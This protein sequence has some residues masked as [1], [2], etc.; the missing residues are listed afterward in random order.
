MTTRGGIRSITV[1]RYED[2]ADQMLQRT[3]AE[4]GDRLMLK[5]G[6]AD[7]IDIDGMDDLSGRAKSY[8]LRAHLDFLMVD[9]ATGLGRFAVELDG[10]Q[11]W[12]DHRTRE[13]DRLKNDLC[14]RAG[15]P[16]LRIT[17]NF[18]RKIGCWPVLTYLT[19]A[20]YLSE[21]FH[22]TQERG[23]IP[24]DESFD[25]QNFFE[26]DASGR[27]TFRATDLRVRQALREH[28]YAGRLPAPCPDLFCTKLVDEGAVQAHAWMSVAPD[29]YLIS[30]V[31]VRDFQFPGIAPFELLEQ[32]AMG[33][34]GEL[35]DQWFRGEGVAQNGRDLGKAVGE[36][37]EAI[38]AVGRTERIVYGP[39]LKA[40]DTS[41]VLR[42][43]SGN[44]HLPYGG[45]VSAGT[46]GD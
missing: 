5:V 33:E 37:Q 22:E 8:A 27:V 39:A 34:I 13:R 31:E 28:C 14:A 2:A 40:G 1:N 10:R 24:F 11:H 21:S 6:L 19:D 12:N 20:F 26:F 23:D 7:A 36:V 3:A 18:A 17:S 35:V 15:L 41:A 4:H 29:R 46:Y 30:K 44:L 32:L 43:P 25:I 42:F 9:T 45:N 16:L 38:D